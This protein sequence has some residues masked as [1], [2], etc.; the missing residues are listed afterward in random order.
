MPTQ[1]P[2]DDDD[3]S[4]EAPST[5]KRSD[6]ERKALILNIVGY[7]IVACLALITIALSLG[8]RFFGLVRDND[9]GFMHADCSLEQNR[10]TKRCQRG[11]NA[12]DK[13]WRD[14]RRSGKDYV[15][16]RLWDGP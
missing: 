15:P 7:S 10:Y 1:K 8:S 9:P 11:E 2:R 6:E 13:D 14:I 4:Y 5:S 16:F 12:S 3:D